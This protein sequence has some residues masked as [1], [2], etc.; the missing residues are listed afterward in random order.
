M[1]KNLQDYIQQTQ[2]ISKLK[3]DEVVA[4]LNKETVWTN[5]D[6]EPEFAFC[7][8]FYNPERDAHKEKP[9]IPYQLSSLNKNHALSKFLEIQIDLIVN[10]YI[11][12][13]LQDITSFTFWNG[14]SEFF[15]LKY[16]T[17]SDGMD[18]HIDHV[19][20]IFDGANRGIPILSIASSLND[21]YEGGEL[22]FWDDTKIKLNKGE[23]LIFPS[24][25]L[26]PH[27]IMPITKGDRYSFVKFIW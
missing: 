26:Y 6:E 17:G 21:D 4:T 7:D 8:Y 3:A 18:T 25:F 16:P 9:N 1:N 27:K 14:K 13:F 22:L 10:N 2:F 5:F 19:R 11:H 12:K 24:I 23:V 15:Y 20:N